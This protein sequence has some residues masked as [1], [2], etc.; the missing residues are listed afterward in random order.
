M[1]SITRAHLVFLRN[2][3]LLAAAGM[4]VGYWMFPSGTRYGVIGGAFIGVI[5]AV[6]SFR[7]EKKETVDERLANILQQDYMESDPECGEH[8]RN[9]RLARVFLA[10]CGGDVVKAKALYRKT[11]GQNAATQTVEEASGEQSA[12]DRSGDNA[13][14]TVGENGLPVLK[15]AP[16]P[17][18]RADA[19]LR[20]VRPA[21]AKAPR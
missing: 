7:F 9:L 6:V 8:E 17:P 15:P 1:S 20:A 12:A 11:M 4:L 14:A 2:A 21:A 10:E 5:S 3:V 16:P 18:K 13:K 19:G